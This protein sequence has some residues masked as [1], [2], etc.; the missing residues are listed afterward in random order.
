MRAYAGEIRKP[1]LD[2]RGSSSMDLDRH[3]D[4]GPSQAFAKQYRARNAW[5]LMYRSVRH[6][7]GKCIAAAFGRRQ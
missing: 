7:D 6:S 1:L 5:G 2:I 3:D 4:Y